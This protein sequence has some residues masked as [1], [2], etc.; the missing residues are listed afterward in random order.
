MTALPVRTPPLPPRLANSPLRPDVPLLLPIPAEEPLDLQHTFRCG[1]VF[2]W[3]AHGDTWYGPF[4]PAS[5]SVRRVP[6]GVEARA[7]GAGVTAGAAWRFLGLHHSL[8]EAAAQ[9]GED[10]WVRAAMAATPGLRI[11]R[12]DPWDCLAGYL[13]SQWNNV[14]KIELSTERVARAWGTVHRWPEGVE[15]ASLPPPEV[16]AA[17]EP[18]EL[19][20]CALGYRCRYL[21]ETARL[22]ASGAAAPAALRE[23]PYEEAL[24][25]LLGLPGVGRKVAD[26]ILLFS[27]DKPQAFP[28]DVWVRRVIHELYAPDL[29]AY[30]P[31]LDQR[32]EKGLSGREYDAIVRFAWERWGALAGWAQEYLFHARRLGVLNHGDA[33]STERRGTEV[34][35]DECG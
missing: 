14:P 3:H 28:V 25:L 10:R 1:Q 30:L 19:Q 32:A 20:P 35:P 18:A 5:L 4:G 26:C 23:A 21:V 11:L 24:R 27:M 29:R 12:Q 2:R 31:D 16:L 7:L 6:E 17:R 34:H 15:V 13:C 8:R 9:F 33:E 22:V